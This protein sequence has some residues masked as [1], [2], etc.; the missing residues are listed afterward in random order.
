MKIAEAAL[1]CGLTPHTIRYYEKSGILPAIERGPDGHRR[2][3][4]ENL[5]W[6]ALLAS[7]RETG[8]PTSK[9]TH[10]ASLYQ[11]GEVSVAERKKMLI[12]HEEHLKRLQERL[13][14]CR[15]ILAHKLALYNQIIGQNS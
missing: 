1:G 2:F 6:L 3:S 4:P 15:K 13:M 8:M 10:F 11:K 7:L 14:N 9:M 5:D 12:E